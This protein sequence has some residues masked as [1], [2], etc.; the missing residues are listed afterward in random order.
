LP[1]ALFLFNHG[2]NLISGSIINIIY[3][4]AEVS[5]AQPLIIENDG[6]K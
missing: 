2:A 5:I 4:M 1:T 6:I 3:L